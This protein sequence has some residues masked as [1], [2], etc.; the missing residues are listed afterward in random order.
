M[1]SSSIATRLKCLLSKLIDNAQTGFIEGR[2]IGEET[3]L[4]YKLINYM[5]QRDIGGL[6]ML[7]DFK[8]AFDLISWKFLYEVL[9]CL[10]S[11]LNHLIPI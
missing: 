10:S 7:I 11:G 2:F 1:A 8:K 6:L 5:E 9:I 3:R 4:I